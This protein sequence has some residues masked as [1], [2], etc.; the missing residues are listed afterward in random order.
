MTALF[1]MVTV[2]TWNETVIR[3]LAGCDLSRAIH[4]LRRYHADEGGNDALPN[5]NGG[6]GYQL[7]SDEH[8]SRC[9]KIIAALARAPM[10]KEVSKAIQELQSLKQDIRQQQA[11]PAESSAND[12][13]CNIAVE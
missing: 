10:S 7:T 5:E 9:N 4:S 12:L 11:Q 6:H 2:A 8:I 13:P 1:V 3:A